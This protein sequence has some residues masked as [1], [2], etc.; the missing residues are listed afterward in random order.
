MTDHIVSNR[1]SILLSIK[2]LLNIAPEDKAFDTDII[3]LINSALSMA[4]QMGIG[5]E[6]GMSISGDN[7]TWS[8]LIPN[9]KLNM[10]SEYV[11]LKTRMVFDPPN[12][13]VLGSMEKTI[14]ELEWRMTVASEEVKENA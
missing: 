13:S 12:G 3:M 11:Y 2:K 8:S 14:S 10:V 5:P 9:D 4:C 7:E 6:N 1:D